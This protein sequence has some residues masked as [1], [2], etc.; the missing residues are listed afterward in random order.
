MNTIGSIV[1]IGVLFG[2]WVY[3]IWKAR[4]AGVYWP[5]FLFSILVWP[6]GCFAGIYWGLD[7]LS[8]YY[9]G[10]PLLKASDKNS[11]YSLKE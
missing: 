10:K 3:Y 9:R 8:L 7:D 1:S 2:G 5:Y 11:K 6:V 4:V